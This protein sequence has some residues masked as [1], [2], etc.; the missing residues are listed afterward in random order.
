MTVKLTYYFFSYFFVSF[1]LAMVFVSLMHPLSFKVGAVDRGSDRRIHMGIIPR[2]GGAGIFFAFLIPMIFSLTRGEWDELH[3]KMVGILIASALVFLMG[4][5]DD[6]RSARIGVKLSVEILAAVIIY[7]WGISITAISNPLGESINLG[8]MSLPVTVLWIVIITNAI[9]LIDGIDGLAAGTSVFIAATLFFLTDSTDLHMRLT[10]V[11]FIGSLIGF[12][13]YNFPP[14]SI[15]MGDSGS[16][17]IGFFLASFSIVS[18]HKATT[19]ATMM[20]P[21]ISFGLP[22]MD[23]LYAVLR[24][25]Y[26]GIPLGEA[27]REHIHHKLLEKGLSKKKVLVIL[28]LINISIMLGILLIVRKQLN[29][30][31]IGCILF[32]FA[33]I[34]GTRILG[35]VKFIPSI[36]E[37]MDSYDIH[38]KGRYFSYI[39][40]KFRRNASESNSLDDFRLQLVD[41]A[42]KYNFNKVEIVLHLPA[43]ENPFFHFENNPFSPN[44]TLLSFPIIY[45]GNCM[46]KASIST[47]T[48]RSSLLYASD[49]VEALSEEIGGFMER[50]LKTDEASKNSLR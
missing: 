31:L 40:K 20:I 28:Y 5:Y 46:G 1:I 32:A 27:D 16:L 9:N 29:V 19:M 8:W 24:R 37:V 4:V 12:L 44:P 41:L 7:T 47:E 49:M 48:A 17:F 6:I 18:A 50:N 26:R 36:R 30:D 38:R 23:M 45:K 14:A 13:K 25:Y 2:L 3:G 39:I 34:V 35:Y 10:L 11:I 21:V 15:F 22:I 42:R 33:I 43:L